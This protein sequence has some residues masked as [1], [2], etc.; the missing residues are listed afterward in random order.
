MTFVTCTRCQH[1]Y[2]VSEDHRK[3]P[4]ACPS[5]GHHRDLPNSI[6]E[7]DGGEMGAAGP[8][9]TYHK[10][11]GEVPVK[12]ALLHHYLICDH[13]EVV[14]RWL[15]DAKGWML[16]IKDG[17]ARVATVFD[18]VPIFG[19]FVFIEIG[20]ERQ[21]DGLRLTHVH[22]F[23]MQTEYALL[24]LV[25]SDTAILDTI[26]GP[27]TLNERQKEHVREHVKSQYL[28]PVSHGIDDLM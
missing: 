5:C 11:H 14:A 28:R 19:D 10:G 9:H 27:A 17:F 23:R 8:I 16:R 6:G 22:A 20:V 21:S 3:Q 18:G 13:R 2:S 7:P 24:N 26:V 15:G 1:T 4:V 12:L 25:K